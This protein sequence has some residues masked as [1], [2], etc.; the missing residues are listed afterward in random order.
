M[1]KGEGAEK[2]MGFL[3]QR[4]LMEWNGRDTSCIGQKSQKCTKQNMKHTWKLKCN[5]HKLGDVI[6]KWRLYSKM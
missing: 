1:V 3:W 6:T 5:F 2:L 4:F